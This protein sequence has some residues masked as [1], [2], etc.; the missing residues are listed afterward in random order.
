MVETTNNILVPVPKARTWNYTV[1]VGGV[2]VTARLKDSRWKRPLLNSGVGTFSCNIINTNN[3]IGAQV[4]KGSTV[5]LKADISDGSTVQFRGRVD[6]PRNTR[7]KQGQFLMLEGRHRSWFLTERRV[8]Y[9]AEEKDVIDILKEIAAEE[10]TE[11]DLSQLPAS[12]GI[13][14]DVQWEYTPFTE[15]VRELM[16]KSGYD[17]YIDDDDLK[18][19]F[20]EQGSVENNN[21]A[22]AEND[23]L[24]SLPEAGQD[25]FFEKTRV[26]VM[27]EDGDGMPIVYTAINGKD[28]SEDQEERESEGVREIFRKEASVDTVEKVK[29]LAR[30]ILAQHT[31][32][33][34]QGDWETLGMVTIKPGDKIWIAVPREGIYEQQRVQQ[35]THRIGQKAAGWRTELQMQEATKE[36]EDLIYDGYEQTRRSTRIQNKNKLRYSFNDPFENEN[37]TESKNSVVIDDGV[38]TLVGSTAGYGV[39]ESIVQT[40][41]TD[42]IT[43]LELRHQGKDLGASKFY[44]SLNAGATWIEF[45]GKNQLV[46]AQTAGRQL[47]VK[48]ELISDENNPQPAVDSLAVLYS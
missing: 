2:D 43:K 14:T 21:E 41:T 46:S 33:P 15:C 31:N 30:S 37:Y 10:A 39:W 19:Y 47:K 9:A 8:C 42:N 44:Y 4:G 25:D 48:I 38:L 1:T 6:Y 32:R 26:T 22:I 29:K 13:T 12:T 5:E 40:S 28:D 35:V 16:E 34:K 23:N 27:G 11:L 24:L 17:S 3:I 7:S 18:I 36:T 45:P 20:F